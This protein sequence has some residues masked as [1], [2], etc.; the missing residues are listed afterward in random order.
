MGAA[1]LIMRARTEKTTNMADPTSNAETHR[2]LRLHESDERLSGRSRVATGALVLVLLA[3]SVFAVWTSQET[4]IAASRAVAANNRSDDYA[5]ATSA[6]AAEESLERKYRLEPG[7]EVRASYD[8]AGAD[9][10]SVMGRVRDGGD[11]S[12]RVFVDSVLAQHRLYLAAIGVMFAAVDRGDTAAALLVDGEQ[13]DPLFVG[14]QKM[15]VGAAAE[16][17]QNALAEL[18]SMQRLETLNP[19]G[20][21]GWL[22]TRRSA[23]IDYR[24]TPPV[25]RCRTDPRGA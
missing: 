21:S 16:Q 22:S 15:V 18:G 12:D 8:A 20:V 9:L 23:R 1:K 7:P 2:G 4:S 25:A 17:H 5:Q 11:A 14:I 13:V 24:W 10:V 6:V 19:C 3:I